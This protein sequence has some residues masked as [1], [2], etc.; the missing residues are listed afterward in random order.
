[1]A[2][3]KILG[4]RCLVKRAPVLN[5]GRVWQ[6]KERRGLRLSYAMSNSHYPTA[7]RLWETSPFCYH[8]KCIDSFSC[9]PRTKILKLIR[10]CIL[11]HSQKS[12]NCVKYQ[13]QT[14]PEI[15]FGPIF[16]LIQTRLN[17]VIVVSSTPIKC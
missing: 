9:Q 12:R 4:L 14:I 7:A 3:K 11:F 1:M 8:L 5:Q 6:R 13:P 15:I 2:L 10:Y 17:Q 16:I